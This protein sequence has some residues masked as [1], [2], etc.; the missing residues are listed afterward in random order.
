MEQEQRMSE[1]AAKD[2]KGA[3]MPPSTAEEAELMP[4]KAGQPVRFAC[5]FE[6]ESC[7]RRGWLGQRK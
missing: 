6:W 5:D 1:P 3:D 4:E 2:A 7:G